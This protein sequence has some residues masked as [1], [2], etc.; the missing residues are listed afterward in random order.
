[1][2]DAHAFPLVLRG[3][4]KRRIDRAFALFL[5]E[6]ETAI[7]DAALRTPTLV[8]PRVVVVIVIIVI[9]IVLKSGEISGEVAKRKR[10]E[11]TTTRIFRSKKNPAS[12]GDGTVF[13]IVSRAIRPRRRGRDR[14]YLRVCRQRRVEFGASLAS[15]LSSSFVLLLLLLLLRF[16]AR[17]GISRV[18]RVL[19]IFRFFLSSSLVGN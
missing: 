10:R 18:S 8:T 16:V 1:M 2:L 11:T 9:I 14:D 17:R 12:K 15:S 4:Q 7:R 19:Y 6:A 5:E 3:G 13:G